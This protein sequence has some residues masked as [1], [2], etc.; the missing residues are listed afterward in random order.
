MYQGR[1]TMPDP[2]FLVDGV[3]EQRILRKL[4]PGKTAI[5]IECNEGNVALGAIV[6]RVDTQIRLLN[7]RYYPVVIL[8]DRET[9]KISCD[10]IMQEITR[11]LNELGHAGQFVV[12]VVDRCIENWIL[13]DWESVC[14]RNGFQYKRLTAGHEGTRGKSLLKR[15]LPKDIFYNEVTWGKE[16][17]LSC[18]PTALYQRSESFRSFLDKLDFPCVWLQGVNQ[19]FLPP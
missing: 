4:C 18:N 8:I 6:K 1:S 13:A 7:N 2:A 5:R 12:G 11:Q 10:K 3:M 17:F 19:R 14:E 16:L 9:R 15:H